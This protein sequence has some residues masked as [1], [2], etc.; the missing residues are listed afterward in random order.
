MTF[1]KNVV[2][3]IRKPQSKQKLSALLIQ[4][5]INRYLLRMPA[6]CPDLSFNKKFACSK[7]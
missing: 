3:E 5:A 6:T 7:N 1:N 4:I 2:C